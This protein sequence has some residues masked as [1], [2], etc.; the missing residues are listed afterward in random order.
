[1]TIS[2]DQPDKSLALAERLEI[3]LTM[4]SD[5]DL[6]VINAYWVKD[7]E[8]DIAWP[9][10]FLVGQEGKILW[11]SLAEH[12]KERPAPEVV[13]EAIDQHIAPASGS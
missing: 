7:A 5:T 2:V 10:I 11:R 1:V 3:T 13:L 6:T 12:Y 9:S 8:L 4:L